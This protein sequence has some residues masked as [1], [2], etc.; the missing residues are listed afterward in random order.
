[1]VKPKSSAEAAS[2]DTQMLL[3]GADVTDARSTLTIKLDPPPV[4][5]AW[6]KAILLLLGGA[7][8]GVIARWIATEASAL[9]GLQNR[10]GIIE[11][12]VAPHAQRLPIAFSAALVKARMQIDNEDT[13][14]AAT[15]LTDLEAKTPAAVMAAIA[16]A[17]LHELLAAQETSI[18][19]MPNLGPAA[20]RL[21]QVI[22]LERSFADEFAADDYSTD[23][24]NE[25]RKQRI[26]DVQRFNAF[27]PDYAIESNR[28]P[29]DDALELFQQD[30]FAAAAE[31]WAADADKEAPLGAAAPPAAPQLA[32]P[33][34]RKRTLRNWVIRRSPEIW[35]AITALALALL[36]LFT[37][38]DPATTFR[39]EPFLDSAEL[40]AWGLGSA[41]TGAGIADL[42]TK[43]S[44][45]K[46]AAP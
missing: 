26:A 5:G 7:S 2:Y 34:A 37:V 12:T 46:P 6:L 27:L 9:R 4:C 40:F 17:R 30:N 21:G 19:S 24:G 44:A 14:G 10:L 25:R 41:L 39:T 42:A 38:Y 8:L 23:A 29:L 31:K 16:T 3:R 1:M 13:S 28:K 45:G 32:S 43:L 15:T 11:T 33:P 22:G 35:L 20:A 36:G 18:A